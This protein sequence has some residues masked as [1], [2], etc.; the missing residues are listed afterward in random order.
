MCCLHGDH[1]P[2]TQTIN[3]VVS[4]ARPPSHPTKQ[5]MATATTTMM[6]GDRA[7]LDETCKIRMLVDILKRLIERQNS[8]TILE[9][10]KWLM[11]HVVVQVFFTL[12]HMCR[13]GY[14]FSDAD[15]RMVGPLLQTTLPRLRFQLFSEIANF[16]KSFYHK[17]CAIRSGLQY[18]L[19]QYPIFPQSGGVFKEALEQLVEHLDLEDYDACFKGYRPDLY[20]HHIDHLLATDILQ[21]PKSHWWWH[22]FPQDQLSALLFKVL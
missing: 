4:R 13:E 8:A 20:N 18:L 10:G 3:S 1:Q 12:Y 21:M 22:R 16:P 9:D 14:R 2:P 15:R 11:E 6:S 17:A 5:N 7:H 19:D